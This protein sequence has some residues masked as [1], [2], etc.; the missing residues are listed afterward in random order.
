[1]FP[2]QKGNTI[3]SVLFRVLKPFTAPLNSAKKHEFMEWRS[4]ISRYQ[5][6][7]MSEEEIG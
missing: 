7:V 3:L 6:N 2:K 5:S 1:M 4:A